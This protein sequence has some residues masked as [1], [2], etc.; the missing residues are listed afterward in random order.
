ME[1]LLNKALDVGSLFDEIT[2]EERDYTCK[3]IIHARRGITWRKP[4]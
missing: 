1:E 4:K 2:Q 3:K